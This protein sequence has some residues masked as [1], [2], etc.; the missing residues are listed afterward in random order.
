MEVLLVIQGMRK[1][2][3]WRRREKAAEPPDTTTFQLPLKTLE[4]NIA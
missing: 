4:L 1:K 2:K 3:E